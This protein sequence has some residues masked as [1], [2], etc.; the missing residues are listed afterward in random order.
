[1]SNIVVTKSSG[2]SRPHVVDSTA[3]PGVHD[4]G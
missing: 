2:L 4:G 1:M 3:S